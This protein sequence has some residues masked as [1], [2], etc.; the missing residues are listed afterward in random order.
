MLSTLDLPEGWEEINITNCNE[1]GLY[2][3]G[4]SNLKSSNSWS[5]G[6][7]QFQVVVST[8]DYQNVKLMLTEKL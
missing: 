8:E 2:A 7:E 1:F 4:I 6:D 5:D 3:I